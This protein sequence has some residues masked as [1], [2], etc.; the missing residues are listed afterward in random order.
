MEKQIIPVPEFAEWS[1][2]ST[3]PV[4]FVVKANG[5]V[6]I[7]NPAARSSHGYVLGA[8]RRGPDT[9]RDEEYRALPQS[10]RLVL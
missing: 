9:P 4:S 7:G 1:K 8:G 2:S 3:T 5:L 10:S 6:F